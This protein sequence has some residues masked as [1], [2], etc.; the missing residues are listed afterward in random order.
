MTHSGELIHEIEGG[1]RLAVRLTPKASSDA[2]G[3]VIDFG[4]APV[5]TA[6]V[7][8]VPDKGEANAALLRL[9]AGWL[10]IAQGHVS[11]AGGGKSRLKS[12]EIKGDPGALIARI[13]Q[14]L[15]GAHGS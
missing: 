7:R 5:L 9:I 3:E 4:G 11:L 13:E 8:A 10:G 2:V 12:V 14:L 1:I 15:A 6:R